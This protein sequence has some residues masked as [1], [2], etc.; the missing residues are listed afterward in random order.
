MDKTLLIAALLL[1]APAA[2]AT[3][4][5]DLAH[6]TGLSERNVRMLLGA[7]TPYGEYRCCY[8]AKL[9]Q[10]KQAL[11]EGNYEKLMRGETIVLE[12]TRPLDQRGLAR[13]EARKP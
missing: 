11:G 4:T 9:R 7:R 3:T 5:S 10:F 12:R 1:A 6:E 2:G 13:M 8:E